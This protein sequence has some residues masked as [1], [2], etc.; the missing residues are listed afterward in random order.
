VEKPLDLMSGII[1]WYYVQGVGTAV[2]R[3]LEF[4]SSEFGWES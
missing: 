2:Y 3:E 4:P 1:R